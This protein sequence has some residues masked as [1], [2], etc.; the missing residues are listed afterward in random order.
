MLM[1]DVIGTQFVLVIKR[2]LQFKLVECV[3]YRVTLKRWKLDNSWVRN[4][5]LF[6]CPEPRWE[7]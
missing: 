4:R 6:D 1:A 7:T 3:T 2:R 5:A